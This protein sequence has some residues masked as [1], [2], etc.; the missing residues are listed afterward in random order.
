MDDPKQNCHNE[1]IEFKIDEKWYDE[2]Y[3]ANQVTLQR[4]II[5]VK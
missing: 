4:K 2:L 3:L 5:C 1:L